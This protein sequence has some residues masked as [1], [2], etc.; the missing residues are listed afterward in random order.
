MVR[1]ATRTRKT[2]FSIIGHAA[3]TL[4]SLSCRLRP[5]IPARVLVPGDSSRL[6]SRFSSIDVRLYVL[7]AIGRKLRYR[8]SD[9]EI[10]I[11]KWAANG[12]AAVSNENRRSSTLWIS[13]WRS[14][15]TSK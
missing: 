3:R 10:H 6:Y 13:L 12:D 14:S 2:C 7:L 4:T 8:L 1:I 5:L 11:W 9:L 15:N